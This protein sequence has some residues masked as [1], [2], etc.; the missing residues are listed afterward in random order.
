MRGDGIDRDT[1]LDVLEAATRFA[2]E[3]GEI[4][5]RYFG[6]L[7]DAESKGDGSPVTMAD[8]EA[9]AH[10]RKR[11][12][13]RWPEHGILGEEF[14]VTREDAPI[15]W[16]LDPI[17]GTR[18]FMRGVPLYS[19]LIGVEGPDGPFVGV[20]H[21]PALGETV[22]AGEG[23]GCLWN[24]NPCAVSDVGELDWSLVLTTDAERILSRSEGQGF[25]SLMQGSSF[26][27]TWGDCYGHILVATG[28]A[29]AMIDPILSS[30]DAG[31]LLTILTEA[32]GT[33]TDLKGNRTIHGGSGISSNGRMHAT[34]LEA[35][36]RG[37]A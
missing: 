7:V 35:L 36:R 2:H 12:E 19:V 16:I 34:V 5:L 24:G 4:T 9:E 15:R 22:A 8:R 6:G 21:F 28:R 25:R 3:A 33:F 37:E 32:G 18:S 11:I 20:A 27:R 30:W 26:S 1:V 10:I 17:D 23:L 14:G 29:E 13:E 31:P